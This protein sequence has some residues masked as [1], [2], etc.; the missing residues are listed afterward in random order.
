[1]P[2]SAAGRGYAWDMQDA[3]TN[4]V[5]AVIAA[6]AAAA[7]ASAVMTSILIRLGHRS[8]ALDSAGVGGHRKELRPIPNIG[9][10]AITWS[11]LLPIAAGLT[12]AASIGADRLAEWLPPFAESARRFASNAQ[13]ACAILIGAAVL[14]IMGL[15]DDRRALPAWPKLLLQCAVAVGVASLGGVRVLMLL[16]AHVGGP[17]LSV[18]LSATFMVAIVNAVNFLDNMD[19]LAGGVSFIAAAA[20][21]TAACISRQ[22]ATAAVLALLA[23]GL[24]GFL[25]F[26]FP[27]R[28]ARPARIFMGDGGSL[29]VGFLL[30]ALAIQITF[31]APDDPEYALGARWYG[32]LTPLVILT[33]PLYDS[34]IVTLL[35]LGQGK[36]PMVGDHQHF[37]HRLVMRGL[38]SRGAV[39]L[40]CALATTCGIGGLLLGTAAPWQAVLIGAQTIMVLLTVAA[41]EQPMLAQMRTGA[42]R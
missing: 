15:I 27:W 6:A 25:V 40:I 8:G 13:P 4:A 33:V 42:D 16:D 2:D 7:L 5:L 31:T 11:V 39:L 32:V 17:W 37:S 34:V 9:G 26:N 35:R 14:H 24:L 1:M 21:C 10:V 28:A 38:S 22:W 3:G 36:S 30:A 41:L 29:P 23:G 20:F 18:A 12:G 19:G